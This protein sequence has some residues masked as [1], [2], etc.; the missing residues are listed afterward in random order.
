MNDEDGEA[1]IKFLVE[2]EDVR[3]LNRMVLSLRRI[4]GVRAVQKSQKV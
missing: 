2:A 4:E 3:H 1:I